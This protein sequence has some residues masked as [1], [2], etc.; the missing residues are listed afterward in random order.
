MHNVLNYKHVPRIHIPFCVIN[1]VSF[2]M[3]SFTSKT[4]KLYASIAKA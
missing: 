3:F 2:V 4:S 1:F